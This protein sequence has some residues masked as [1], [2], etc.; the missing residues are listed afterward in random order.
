VVHTNVG[1]KVL[2]IN[3]GIMT[4]SL[5]QAH[6]EGRRLAARLYDEIV[7]AALGLDAT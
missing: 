4:E 6:P 1:W 3:S 7:C 2:E 5:V